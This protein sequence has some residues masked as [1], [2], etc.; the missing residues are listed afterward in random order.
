M[1]YLVLL[2]G[3]LASVAAPAMAEDLAAVFAKRALR[4]GALVTAA[5]VE[6]R[7]L[8][9]HRAAGVASSLDAVIGQEVRRNFYVNRPVQA[10]DVGVPTVVH[11]NSIVALAY[12]SGGLELT[13]VGR[14]I[15]SAGLHELI[16]VVNID[17]RV[18]VVGKVTGPGTV[19]V[20]GTAGTPRTLP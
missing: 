17:S 8:S 16:R 5:D 6:L 18:T 19:R 10:E 4:V 7:P 14:A 11:R 2:I 12:G 1:R 9:D 3:C 15:D 20:G 13:T